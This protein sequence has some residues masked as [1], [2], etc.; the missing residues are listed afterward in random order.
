[1]VR[2]IQAAPSGYIPPNDKKLSN[3]LLD[4][5]YGAMWQEMQRRDPNGTLKHKFGSC[6]VS[7]GWDSCDALPLINSAFIT[8]NDG[9]MFW[10]SVDTSGHT[11]S[12]EYCA[13]LMIQDIYDF[14]PSDVILVITDTCSTMAKA[15]ALVQDEFP[16]ISV[17]PCQA[18]VISLLMKGM[19][20]ASHC[21]LS[22]LPSPHSL[23]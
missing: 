19:C 2:A 10:R 5:A 20:I 3:E 23:F 16:W 4:E 13:L 17:L 11:K 1:M 9:G 14:G 7:D 18:H 6:Y 22:H 8:A 15:W 21:L 12:A